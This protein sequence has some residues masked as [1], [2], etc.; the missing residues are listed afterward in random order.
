MTV[1][2]V[3]EHATE[4]ALVDVGHPD[5]GRLLGDGL[6]RL[7]L[8]AD[9]QHLAA[10][11]DGVLDERVGAVDVGQRLLQVDDVDAV[12]LGEDEALH[13]GVPA[14]GLV[15]E[16][17]AALEELAGG[18]DGHGR[19]P[20]LT[21]LRWGRRTVG[22]VPSSSA[23]PDA[24]H[25]ASSADRDR[26][27]RPHRWR[28]AG[29]RSQPSRAAA[30]SLHRAGGP[31]GPLAPRLDPP[32]T[33][34]PGWVRD[35][36]DDADHDARDRPRAP[37]SGVPAPPDGAR[38]LALPQ[39]ELGVR[40]RPR[41]L[42]P[43]ARPARAPARRRDHRPLRP[44]VGGLR[45]RRRRLPRRRLVPPD[46]GGPRRSGP[47]RRV[48]L[49]FGAVDHDATVWVDGIEVGPAPRRLH[50]V[51]R[52]PHRR[53]SAGPGGDDRRPRPRPRGGPAGARQA[54]GPLR[55]PRL[56]LH[57]DHRHLADGLAGA[58][59]RR[60][61]APAADHPA[62]GQQQLRRRPRRCRGNL[63][64]SRVTAVRAPTTA[65]EVAARRGRR[66]PRPRARASCWPCR[67][68]AGASGR[69]RTRTS[70]TSS[71]CSR[72]PTASWT[73]VHSYAGLRSVPIDGDAVLINGRHV[74]QRLVLDQG[75]WPQTPDDRA[76]RPGA[77]RRHRAGPGGRLQRRPA[78]PEGL[79]GALPL[80]RRPAG[81]PGLG[82]VR[83]LGL[84]A[85][86]AR[87]RPPAADGQLRHPVARGAGARLQPPGDH[88]LVPAER[89]LAAARRPDH[90][91]RRRHPRDVPGHQ[92]GRPVAAGAGRLRLLPPG[93][94]DRHLGQPQLRAG[95]G[96]V[97]RAGR[98]AGR[99]PRLHQRPRRRARSPSRYRGQ[100]YFVS[101]FGGIWW[102]AEVAARRAVEPGPRDL[103]GLR[104]AGGATGGVLRSASPAWS[105]RC[106]TTRACSATATPS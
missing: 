42:R 31:A 63:P 16:V 79:R 30:P 89:D 78:A 70:T 80:P 28:D 49:H 77:D 8:G 1:L 47:T 76:E 19:I 11:G 82:R 12:A 98:R 91:A 61:P 51:H 53:W 94:G 65:G 38:P 18:D 106:S 21:G 40:G 23:P 39:R 103:L 5:P 33:G 84:P 100:P 45:R 58:G 7:L 86:T 17:D 34:A 66:R 6:L 29:M 26:R 56:P 101:E 4:P 20:F 71:S 92:A 35:H 55:Q 46:G 74:F 2:E 41:R 10:A 15:P 50:P 93:A 57:P 52:R 68:T 87:R 22:S 60:P 59:A 24:R 43:G 96:R 67:R 27:R 3:G 99:G 72:R 81:L 90:P 32:G 62:A 97:R 73:G 105:R 37:P 104:P 13:L 44:R 64:G 14:T 48:L 102:N 69:R 85:A 54:V 9:E 36:D 88:R 83:R 75:Y 25:G 95:P